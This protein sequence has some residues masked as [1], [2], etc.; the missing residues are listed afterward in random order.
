MHQFPQKCMTWFLVCSAAICYALPRVE[1]NRDRR[2]PQATHQC[3]I[4]KGKCKAYAQFVCL[5]CAS[6]TLQSCCFGWNECFLLGSLPKLIHWFNL[7]WIFCEPLSKNILIHSLFQASCSLHILS[8]PRRV[9]YQRSGW[10][11]TGNVNS[12]KPKS[13]RRTFRMRWMRFCDQRF[14][15]SFH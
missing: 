8:S 3:N 6:S 11:L 12:Q 15:P 9:P 13:L 10:P 5:S 1:A 4:L 14:A 7:S 2:R